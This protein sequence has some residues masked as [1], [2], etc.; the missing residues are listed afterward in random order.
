MPYIL[1]TKIK[2][3]IP[4]RIFK[5]LS[6]NQNFQKIPLHFEKNELKFVLKFLV[7]IL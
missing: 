7:C 4:D 3:R 1:H 2:F 6:Q 5:T